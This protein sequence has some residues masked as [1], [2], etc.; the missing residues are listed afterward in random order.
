MTQT[1]FD[2]LRAL[3]AGYAPLDLP[4]PEADLAAWYRA[5]RGEK[6]QTLTYPRVVLFA[7]SHAGHDIAPAQAAVA[8]FGNPDHPVHQ[9]CAAIDTDF[10]V[11][12]LALEEPVAE[13]TLDDCAHAVAYG[14]MMVDE[15]ID[16]I[17]AAAF[18]AGTEASAAQLLA[19][20]ATKGEPLEMLRQHGGREIA[21]TF[22]V[23]LAARLARLPVVLGGAGAGA[24]LAVL[25]AL[26]PDA[27]GH[28]LNVPGADGALAAARGVE[29]LQQAVRGCL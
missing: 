4:A 23:I 1:F 27:G 24:A 11:H 3:V 17:G 10:S 8:A 18:G 14:M 15:V 28:C 21:A 5:L 7:G 29:R 19:G 2:E 25:T 22:G 12:D 6:K 26:R 20:L 13:M 16:V 9:L